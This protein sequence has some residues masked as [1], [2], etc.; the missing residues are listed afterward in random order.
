MT[1]P[2]EVKVREGATPGTRYAE[3]EVGAKMGEV[4]FTITPDIIEEYIRAVEGDEK[5]YFVNGRKAAPPDVLCPYMTST[6]YQKYPPIQGIIMC[7]VA[8]NYHHPIWRDETTEIRLSGEVT[9]KF[10]KMH[11]KFIKWK[12]RYRR[13]D[14]V[15]LA[16]VENTFDLPE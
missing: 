13:A 8:F 6:L 14:G 7:E 1:R 9:E 12:G 3:F 16:E 5:L 10:E 15:L 2:A 4:T 11:H